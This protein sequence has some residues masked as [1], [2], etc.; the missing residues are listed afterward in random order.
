MAREPSIY[1]FRSFHMQC[2]KAFLK[3]GSCSNYNFDKSKTKFIELFVNKTKN[4]HSKRLRTTAVWY[5]S[6]N[7][8]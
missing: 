8:L 6:M 7:N 5:M 3:Q 1:V 2:L 4:Q